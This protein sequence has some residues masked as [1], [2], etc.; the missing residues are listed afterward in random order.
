MGK[1]ARFVFR[2]GGGCKVSSLPDTVDNNGAKHYLGMEPYFIQVCG[3]GSTKEE[4]KWKE[5]FYLMMVGDLP[6]KR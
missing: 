4:F 1:V 2:G 6:S 3:E 5:N